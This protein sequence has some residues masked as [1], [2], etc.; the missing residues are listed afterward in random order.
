MRLTATPVLFAALAVSLPAVAGKPSF[1]CAKATHEAEQLVCKD[2][3]L[4]QLDRNLAEIYSGLLKRKTGAEREQLKGG[5][6]SWVKTRNE[7]WKAKD[8]HA[9]VQ[10]EYQTRIDELYN[11][12]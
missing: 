4:A 9:C 2:P 8:P 1:D 5:Q 12:R 6:N 10:R 3:E 7:C 11:W